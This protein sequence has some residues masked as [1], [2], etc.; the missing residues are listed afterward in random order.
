MTASNIANPT[1]GNITLSWLANDPINGESVPNGTVIFQLCFGLVESVFKPL[2]RYRVHFRLS[3]LRHFPAFDKT[4]SVPYL[5][6]KV[7][8]LLHQLFIK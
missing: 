8:S 3:L 5:V 1:S 2:N 4:E 6:G 7:S